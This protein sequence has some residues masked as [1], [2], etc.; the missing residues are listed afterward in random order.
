MLELPAHIALNVKSWG[1]T[2][3]PPITNAHKLLAENRQGYEGAGIKSTALLIFTFDFL[4]PHWPLS[5][6]TCNWRNKAPSPVQAT[7]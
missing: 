2:A 4:H 1:E 6:F 3:G 7:D 5:E